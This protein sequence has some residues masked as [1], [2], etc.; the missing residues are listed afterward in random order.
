LSRTSRRES[1]TP[2]RQIYKSRRSLPGA[3]PL[4]IS[5]GVLVVALHGA[6]LVGKRGALLVRFFLVVKSPVEPFDS[7]EEGRGA[8]RAR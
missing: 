8:K 3:R 1:T 7:S 5:S 4:T 2:L 6:P